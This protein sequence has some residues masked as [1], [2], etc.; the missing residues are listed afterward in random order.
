MQRFI[1]LIDHLSTWVGK[2]FAWAIVILTFV[3]T[4]EVF[5]RYVLSAPTAWAYDTSYML[6]GTLFMMCGAYALAGN[7]HVRAD[8]VSRHFPPRTQA[9]LDLALYLVFF[10][11]GILALIWYGWDFFGLSYRQNEHSSF[12]PGGPPIYPFKFVIPFAALL[13]LIQGFAEVMRCLLCLRD[14]RWPPRLG[15]VEEIP[16]PVADG[17]TKELRS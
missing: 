7:A 12:T 5:M 2:F 15:D 11:P 6:Y 4:Y 13:L 16:L 17:D 10:Y 3:V 8:V 9:A 1:V 14:G